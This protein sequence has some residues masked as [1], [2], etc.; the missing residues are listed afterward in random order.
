MPASRFDP[1]RDALA[2]PSLELPFHPFPQPVQPPPVMLPAPYAPTDRVSPPGSVLVPLTQADLLRYLHPKNRLRAPGTARQAIE[3]IYDKLGLMPLL[4]GESP[5]AL[6]ASSDRKRPRDDREYPEVS[7]PAKRSRDTSA[8]MNHYN[9][10]ANVSIYQRTES[11]II[12]LKSFNNWVKSVLIAKFARTLFDNGGRGPPQGKVLDMGCGKGGDLQKWSK[13]RIAEYVGLDVAAVSVDDARSRWQQLRVKNK[14]RADFAAAD[15]FTESI[16]TVLPP[17]VF[18]TPFDVVSMQFCMHYA[19]ESKAKA[20]M[21]LRNVSSHLRPG[22]IFLGTIPNSQQL[23]SQLD[24]IQQNGSGA[25]EWGNSVYSFRFDSLT[26]RPMFGHRYSFFLK[27][28][29][30]DVPEYVVHWDNFLDMASQH[31]LRLQYREEFH[32]VFE[33][34]RDDAEFGPLLER[35]NVVDKQGESH[36]DEDQWEAA[37]IYIAFAF[38]KLDPDE[39]ETSIPYS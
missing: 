12:G 37:N 34:E 18:A 11:P 26:D 20:E 6:S 22:G 29:V 4:R 33:A 39:V 17:E 5:A 15:C 7:P 10:R 25:P 27:D 13:A 8:V 19:F 28:A 1:I 14:F 9:Q 3:G 2:S 16:D 21:M 24:F 31:G 38:V 30:D 32:D 35:M 36:M 23:M